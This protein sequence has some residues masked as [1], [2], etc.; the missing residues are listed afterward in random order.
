MPGSEELPSLLCPHCNTLSYTEGKSCF[1]HVCT[2][3]GITEGLWRICYQQVTAGLSPTVLREK[4]SPHKGGEE[5][6]I[7]EHLQVNV[8]SVVSV[9]RCS[10]W[11]IHKQNPNYLGE[12]G[13]FYSQNWMI[14]FYVSKQGQEAPVKGVFSFLYSLSTLRKQFYFNSELLLLIKSFEKLLYNILS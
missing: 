8:I 14:K 2:V 3:S 7:G 10:Y 5:W 13:I 9:K 6:D 1:T 4:S 11:C 12:G